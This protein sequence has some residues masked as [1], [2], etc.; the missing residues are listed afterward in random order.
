VAET[1]TIFRVAIDLTDLD[2][3]V[4]ASLDLS[5]ARHPSETSEHML[6]RVL[7]YCLEYQEGIAFTQGVSTG[8]EP[9]IVIRDLTGQLTAWI[10]VGLPDASRLHRARKA[11]EHVAVYTHRD[12][13][14]WLL[15]VNGAGIRQASTIR[16]RAFE[17]TGIEAWLTHLDRRMSIAL[18]V[19]GGEPLV[20]IGE[21][22]FAVPFTE[23]P[24]HE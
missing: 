2:R 1:A 14:Q 7:A 12:I 5:V 10:E 3:G 20:S 18:T 6:V 23:H 24:L 16:V 22:S 19:S 17:R 15:S 8:D 21:A 11:A 4:Y 13:R 9:A